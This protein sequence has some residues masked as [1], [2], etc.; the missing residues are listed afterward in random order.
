MAAI[1][2]V[3][4]LNPLPPPPRLELPEIK[5]TLI[6]SLLDVRWREHNI[7]LRNTEQ[8]T[9]TLPL[10]LP[11]PTLWQDVAAK[12]RRRGRRRADKKKKKKGKKKG[13]D[14]DDDDDDDDDE[15]DENDKL[16]SDEEDMEDLDE[17]DEDTLRR[18]EKSRSFVF[19]K[20]HINKLKRNIEEDKYEGHKEFFDVSEAVNPPLPA[21]PCFHLSSLAPLLRLLFLSMQDFKK[22]VITS[23]GRSG[24]RSKPNPH[25]EVRFIATQ[26]CAQGVVCSPPPVSRPSLLQVMEDTTI[27]YLGVVRPVRFID[28]EHAWERDRMRIRGLFVGRRASQYKIL[29]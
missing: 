14:D 7:H 13:S 9:N 16:G 20:L 22:L 6:A 27:K 3:G 26:M 25:S 5:D 10:L 12:G 1:D 18:L 23:Y 17:A 24:Q 15:E 29:F 19:E 2:E 28:R 8:C 21:A 4:T 11:P